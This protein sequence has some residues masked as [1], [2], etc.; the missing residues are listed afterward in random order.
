MA[1]PN[2][3]E[4]LT[5][6]IE[7][8]GRSLADNVTTNNALLMRLK[9]KGNVKPVSGGS[10][11][12]QELEYAENGTFMYYSGYETLNISPSDVMTAAEFSSETGCCCCNDFWA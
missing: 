9:E 2:I 8:R 4:L 5:T 12:R 7:S 6:T 11:I 10:T 3:S 1:S